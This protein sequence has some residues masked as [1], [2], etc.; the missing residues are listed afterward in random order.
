MKLVFME[1]DT[2]GKDVDLSAFEKLGDVTVYGTSA[3]E[4]NAKRIEDADVIIVNKIPMNEEILKTAKN[5]KLICLT[6]TGTNNVDF[7]YVASRGITVTNVSGYSTMSVVQHTFAMLFYLYEKLAY[8]D[9]YVKSGQY[10]RSNMFSHFAMSFHELDGKTWGIIGLGQIGR[11]VAEVASSFGCRVLYYSTSGKHDD[12]V[13]SRVDWETLLAESDIISIHAPLS[14]ATEGLV[15]REAFQKMKQSAILLNLGRGPIICQGAL[16]DALQKGEIAG[17]GL[18]VLETE[19]ISAKDSLM[20]M[21]DSTKLLITPHIGWAT[22][23]ARRRCADE[24]YKNIVSWKKGESR[25]V[26]S[27]GYDRERIEVGLRDE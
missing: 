27:V 9:K 1:A 10:A 18:D 7:A 17:A 24:V 14:K 26:V 21:Q 16:A 3:P 5:L 15:D 4:E 13:F 20:Q 12:K 11:K 2:L 22:C 25:N 23:E 8:Y 6:A 19:P